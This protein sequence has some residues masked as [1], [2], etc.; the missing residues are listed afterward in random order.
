MRLVLMRHSTA[1]DGSPDHSR[2]LAPEG[3]EQSKARGRDLAAYPFDL[4]IVSDARR[5]QETFGLLG[6]DI[7]QVDIDPEI[8]YGS[9]QDI[10]QKVRDLPE[11]V[12]TALIVGHEPTI[13]HAAAILGQTS[14]RV[15]EVRAGVS[16]ATAIVIDFETWDGPG[17]IAEIYR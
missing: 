13:S 3:R 12:S 8:Y 14:Q 10:V 15:H 1:A 9:H 11:S 6:L 5:T 17:T 4:A 7:P 2:S 16:T